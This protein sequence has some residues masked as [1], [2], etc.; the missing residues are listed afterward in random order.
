MKN[1]KKVVV[2]KAAARK[3]AAVVKGEPA[4][5][6]TAD[7]VVKVDVVRE[8][9]VRK[10]SVAAAV[11]RVA[12]AAKVA[13][14]LVKTVGAVEKEAVLRG[15]A[16][17]AVALKGLASKAAADVD[18]AAVV[19]TSPPKDNQQ[20]NKKGGLKILLGPPNWCVHAPV[21]FLMRRV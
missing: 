19:V 10:G 20:L 2:K 18:A 16:N 8:V 5:A 13:L 6:K 12:N 3:V 7:V 17:K 21:K 14:A 9:P 1:L 15:V 11:K 4:H